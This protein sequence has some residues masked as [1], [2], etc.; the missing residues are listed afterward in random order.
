MPDNPRLVCRPH[1]HPDESLLSYLIRLQVANG[2]DRLIWL[3]AWLRG[4]TTVRTRFRPTTTNETVFLENL[5]AVTALP[6][7]DLYRMTLNRYVPLRT[8]PG[9]PVHYHRL[10]SGEQVAFCQHRHT[11]KHWSR[12]EAA[13]L[14]CPYCVREA[15]YHR[16]NWMLDVVFVCPKH[17]GWL[18]DTCASCGASVSVESVVRSHCARCSASLAEMAVIPGDAT[19]AA[20][21]QH[22]LVG[23]ETGKLPT[24][25]LPPLSIQALFRLLDGLCAATRLLG[26]EGCYQPE[27]VSQ[28]PFPF[29]SQMNLSPVQHGSLYTSA[30]LTANDWPHSFHRFLDR[31]LQRSGQGNGSMQR[32]LGSFYGIWLEQQ[33][34]HADLEPVQTAFNDYFSAQFLPTRQLLKLDRVQR[35]PELREHMKWFDVRNAARLLGVSSPTIARMVRDG[36]VRA[37]YP[38]GKLSAGGYFVYREDLEN[39]LQRRSSS[40]TLNQVAV[41]FFTTCGIVRE[42][43]ETGLMLQTGVRLIRGISHPCLTRQDVDLFLEQVAHCAC[44]QPERPAD[45]VTLKMVCTHNNKIGM[46]SA[47]VFQRI[48]KGMLHVYHT[49]PDLQP[50]GD[51][52]FDPEEVAVLTQRVKAENNWLSLREVAPFLHV[53]L[54]L[55]RFWMQTGQLEPVA[56]FSRSIYFDRAAVAAFQQR[57]LRS[58]EVAKWLE[59]SDAALSSWVRAG[60][61]PVLSGKEGGQGKSY[62]FD[63]EV[64]AQWS[65]LY[66]TPGEARRILGTSHYMAFRQRVRRGEFV[67]PTSA[68]MP[69]K[70][71]YRVDVQ[72]Y[73]ATLEQPL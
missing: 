50:F 69:D 40:V 24:N 4:K 11:L 61:L 55:V 70:F 48:L 66:V 64:I 15:P 16:L 10:S 1:P 36:Y 5:A 34:R 20:A 68:E 37:H 59:T 22:L 17:G 41:E 44:V 56:Q 47:R 38:Q 58:Q 43:I 62:R 65:A 52:W 9:R 6:I 21:Q 73:L 57:L 46:T 54:K 51:L 35:Y 42:W 31:Q 13:T 60:Y 53:E 49:N 63:R 72:R 23:L 12:T 19:V 30:W 26:W 27:R 32:K 18:L 71:Y 33:W 7:F 25:T 2:Y 67:S 39:G 14:F 45:A 3:I 8:F 28:H 29:S